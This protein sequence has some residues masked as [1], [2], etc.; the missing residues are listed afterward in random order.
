[1]LVLS[2]SLDKLQDNAKK[3]PSNLKVDPAKAMNS[4]IKGIFSRKEEAKTPITKSTRNIK[5]AD[6]QSEVKSQEDNL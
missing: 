1:V 3:P 6:E 4:R 2:T 5:K